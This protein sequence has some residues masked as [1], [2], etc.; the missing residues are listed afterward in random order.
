MYFYKKQGLTMTFFPML[1]KLRMR[2]RDT[3]AKSDCFYFEKMLIKQSPNMKGEVSNL[4]H[5]P[6]VSLYDQ[7]LIRDFFTKPEMYQKSKFVLSAVMKVAGEGLFMADGEK[8]KKHRKI[9]SQVFHYEF[10][11]L[12]V[13]TIV[14]TTRRIFDE[15]EKPTNLSNIQITDEYQKISGEVVGRIFFG[16]NLNDYK[17]EGKFLTLALAELINE[18]V[19]LGRNPLKMLLGNWI[20]GRLRKPKVNSE[21]INR[22]RVF[23]QTLIDIK[24]SK[25][26]ED[27]TNLN[28]KDLLHVLLEHQQNFGKESITDIEII[29]E[30]ISFFFAG[31]DTTA[32]L[33]TMAAY[34]LTQNPAVAE[35]LKMEITHLYKG[36]SVDEI[37]AESINQMKYLDLVIRETLRIDSPVHGLIPRESLQDHYI[38]DLKIKKGTLVNIS[39]VALNYNPQSHED[40]RKFDPERWNRSPSKN[41]EVFGYLPFG[42][43]SRNCIGQHLSQL[44]AKIILCEFL[45]RFDFNLSPD[46]QHRMA[47][48]LLYQPDMPLRFDLTKL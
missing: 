34:H 37:T 47:F 16:N 1:G 14:N 22:F 30:F 9:I 8:W 35:N 15:L 29:D 17:F 27:K 21:K 11:K 40:P 19:I 41:L 2:K 45:T 33:V 43:G 25:L 5:L 12:W 7:E 39:L 13:P 46:Y 26:K 31:M 44:E 32:H 38:G 28:S 20:F 24:K 18:S 36:R 6:M 4:S 42:A 10:L 48:K 23:C 3:I